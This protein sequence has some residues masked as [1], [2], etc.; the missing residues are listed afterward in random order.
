MFFNKVHLLLVCVTELDGDRFCVSTISA[1][2]DALIFIGLVGWI[3]AH[4]K[5]R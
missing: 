5:Q 4:Q 1:F 3:N 2:K